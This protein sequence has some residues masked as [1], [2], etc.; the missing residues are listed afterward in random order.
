MKHFVDTAKVTFKAGDG[1]DGAVSFRRE[2]YVP[3]G[4]PDGGDGGKG[5]DVFVIGD[6][7]LTTLLDFQESKLF[8]A[9]KG[10][11]GGNK[12][13]AG[14]SGTDLLIKVPVG[15][16]LTDA[17]TGEFIADITHHDQMQK[18]VSGGNGGKGNA[19]FKSSTNQVPKEATP[20][21]LGE[22]RVVNLE[23]KLLA[24]VGLIGFPN[25]G[26]STLLSVIT[27]AHPAIAGYRFTTLY[28]NLGVIKRGD[29]EV[30]VADIPGL[31]QGAAEGKGLGDEFL[32]H[33]ERT[34]VLLH[35]LD[36]VS[37]AME[38]GMEPSMESV[39]KSYEIIRKEVQS[40]SEILSSKKELLVITKSDNQ[41][42]EQLLPQIREYFVRENKEMM[43]ISSYT[44]TGIPE[45]IEKVLLMVEQ[46][47][48]QSLQYE[49]TPITF[50]PGDLV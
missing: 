44:K 12:N 47:P 5:G 17:K 28:P 13:M 20:G 11:R 3:K 24:D 25:A 30:L 21:E 15:T 37:S 46:S 40:Y 38:V 33:V 29:T 49:Y 16:V 19:R 1:G 27:N 35:L 23:L 10:K 39:I 34:R 42:T 2:K 9:K 8:I 6:S 32:R 18:V 14:A 31:I 26:K 50:T 36:P 22:Q 7:N 45:L 4:G 43:V 48:E 41:Q